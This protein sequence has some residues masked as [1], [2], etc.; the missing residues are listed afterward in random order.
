[1]LGDKQG[2]KALFSFEERRDFNQNC[3][4]LIKTSNRAALAAG[5][6]DCAFG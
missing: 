1:M 6:M 5:H 2:C 4:D 3:L